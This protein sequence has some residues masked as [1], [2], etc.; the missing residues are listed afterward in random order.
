MRGPV[1]ALVEVGRSELVQ[2]FFAERYDCD[3]QHT[4]PLTEDG[5]AFWVGLGFTDE[6]GWR[7][8]VW[9]QPPAPP[10]E[11]VSWI[12]RLSCRSG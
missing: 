8:T 6:H 11:P 7:L 4:C 9:A 3:V 1:T 2:D 10:P 5:S 12:W